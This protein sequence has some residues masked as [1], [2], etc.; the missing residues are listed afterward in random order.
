MPDARRMAEMI[1]RHGRQ[2]TLQLAAGAGAFT[3]VAIVAHVMGFDA[4]AV[5]DGATVQQGVREIRIA[6]AALDAAGASRAPRQ[7][8]R[9]VV[10][11]KAM[12]IL[13][14][15]ARAL[16]GRTALLVIQA[17]GA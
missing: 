7:G 12:A 16:R 9:I 10:D 4:R 11:G 6:Q 15:D 8:D 5:A 3:D 1:G 17:K 2:V 13:S 14:V